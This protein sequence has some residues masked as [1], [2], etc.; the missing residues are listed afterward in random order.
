MLAE[1]SFNINL[2][3]RSRSPNLPSPSSI[4]AFICLSWPPWQATTLDWQRCSGVGCRPAHLM[5][6]DVPPVW[7][8][9]VASVAFLTC[10]AQSLAV[11]S[12]GM[13][14]FFFWKNFLPAMS[15]VNV[16]AEACYPPGLKP[17]SINTAEV[18]LHKGMSDAHQTLHDHYA[19]V[20]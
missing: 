5:L 20:V 14:C 4:R 19:F 16:M 12:T 18:I 1:M 3:S 7:N 9:Y 2:L 6:S 10:P 13:G 15:G 8:M 11:R 17:A